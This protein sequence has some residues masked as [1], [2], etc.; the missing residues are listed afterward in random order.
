VACR[1]HLV[2]PEGSRQQRDRLGRVAT[3]EALKLFSELELENY[4]N[5]RN[6][7]AVF[8]ILRKSV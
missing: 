8:A 2:T 3:M 5:L 1:I 4:P 6:S 7:R